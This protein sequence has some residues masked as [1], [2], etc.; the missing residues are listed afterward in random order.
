MVQLSATRCSCIAILWV[1][2]VSFAAITLCVTSQRVFIVV[3]L[4]F[5]TDSVRKVLDTPSYRPTAAIPVTEVHRKLPV[6][7]VPAGSSL[8]SGNLTTVPCVTPLQIF[9]SYFSKINLKIILTSEP[10]YPKWLLTRATR[11]SNFIF[12]LTTLTILGEWCGAASYLGGLGFKFRSGDRPLE[13]KSRSS[14]LWCLVVT[15]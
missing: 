10:R 11:S 12:E 7:M 3:S 2:L 13:F 6:I 15:W 14:M 1:S 5:V 8:R 9:T 4:N